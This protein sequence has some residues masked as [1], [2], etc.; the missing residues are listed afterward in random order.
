MLEVRGEE[1]HDS[2]RNRSR[3][4]Q[5]H[6]H[7]HAYIHE[8]STSGSGIERNRRKKHPLASYLRAQQSVDTSLRQKT[9]GQTVPWIL[10]S[11]LRYG[12]LVETLDF[13]R[14]GRRGVSECR[15]GPF[16]GSNTQGQSTGIR[17]LSLEVTTR[18]GCLP[19][20]RSSA[21]PGGVS[22]S[23]AITTVASGRRALV[24]RAQGG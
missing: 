1:E 10:G 8:T 20:L 13:G 19:S 17:S 16:G 5:K 9:A 3:S 12:Y 22:H 24:G 23:T 18:T 14:P 7:K 2:E 15:A 4:N 21:A 11:L 6:T